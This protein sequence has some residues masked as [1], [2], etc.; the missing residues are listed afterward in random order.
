ML[1][2][3]QVGEIVYPVYTTMPISTGPPM[4]GNENAVATNQDASM[5]KNPP[6]ETENGLPTTSKFVKDS[7][8]ARPCPSN[9]NCGP[10]KMTSETIRSWCPI[11]KTKKHTLQDEKIPYIPLKIYS[12][13]SIPLNLTLSL[14]YP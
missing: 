14:I 1:V 5:S 11:H 2:W 4:T 7:D 13:P 6:V 8:A 3:T 9:T 12:I 10:A